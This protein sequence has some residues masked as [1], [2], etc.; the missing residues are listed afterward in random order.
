MIGSRTWLSFPRRH[1][2]PAA[3]SAAI[4]AL[5]GCAGTLMV[6]DHGLPLAGRYDG[7]ANRPASALSRWWARFGSPELTRFVDQ[8]DL[9]NLDL[10]AALARVEQAEAQARIA[11][12]TLLPALSLSADATRAQSSGTTS[13][14]AGIR[15]ASVGNA[16]SGLLAAS[17]ELD[18]W[19]RN[20]DL[21]NAARAN[22]DAAAY[23]LEVVRLSTRAALVNAY[24]TLAASRER[25]AIA[26]E[27]LRNAERI[28][29][30]IR[31]RLN[32]G[33]G[34]A[35]DVA[36]Q[37]SL[38]ASQ[39][40]ALPDLRQS[41]ETSRTAIALL[42]GRPPEGFHIATARLAPLRAPGVA[43]GQPALV[44]VR[45]PD[46]RAAEAQ[47]VAASADLAAA[48]KA[49]LPAIQLTG[50]IGVRS[51]MLSNIL[52]P[53]SAVWSLASGLTQPI[54]DGGRLKAQVW[55]SEA[56][57]TELLE[58]YR[59]AIVSALVDVENALVAARE[60][61]TREAAQAIV[62]A[63]A[64]EAFRLSEE[65]LRLGTIDLQTLLST[66]NTLFQA[67]DALVRA[68]LSR[69]QAA[70]ALFQALG[71]DFMTGVDIRHL[72]APE[73]DEAFR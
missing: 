29:S 34:S 28:L 37:E 12:A 22:A 14:L 35:L 1:A 25:F 65:R 6:P 41:I 2:G 38:V 50:Q 55:L 53:E 3:L 42:L 60:G 49:L 11:G 54:F 45:R 56:R 30:V 23:T 68:R 20:R 18:I 73:P 8:A 46:I 47:L 17:Y 48:R 7:A 26:A 61:A 63:K 57:Q 13:R 19:G 39:R 62:V 51:A 69:L 16:F 21:L 4:L 43:P 70:V 66:Q 72:S 40:A 32:A 52:R 24:L 71:G 33:T 67:Q 36:Q 58:T 31:E 9:A 59:K 15:P 44:L 64:R 10:A 27:N 5:A